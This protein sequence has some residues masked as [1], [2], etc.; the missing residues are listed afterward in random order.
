MI[1]P[2]ANPTLARVAFELVVDARP[3]VSAR[4]EV[5]QAMVTEAAAH[6]K[7]VEVDGSAVRITADR[8]VWTAHLRSRYQRENEMGVGIPNTTP[9][10]AGREAMRGLWGLR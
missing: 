3:P 8:C 6:E 5:A 7:R 1:T 9:S 10:V 4:V 2:E